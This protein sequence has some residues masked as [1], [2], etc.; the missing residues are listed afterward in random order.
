MIPKSSCVSLVA[1]VLAIVSSAVPAAAQS[2]SFVN[3]RDAVPLKFFSPDPAVTH[4]DLADPNT[5]VIGFESGRDSG[6]FLDD[7]F[8][9]STASFGN[10]IA[11]DTV[12]FM[13]V[14]PVGYYVASITYEQGGVGSILR[15]ADAVGGTNWVI[16]GEAASLGFFRADPTLTR[17]ATFTD[18]ELTV[19]PV[20]ITTS[21]AAFAASSTTGVANVE[22]TSAKVV[23][24]VAPIGTGEVKKN[25]VI[26]VT[27]FSGIYDALP[28][29][30]VGTATGV[31]GE[32][33]TPLLDFGASFTDVPGGTAHWTFIG[34][35]TYNAAAGTVPIVIDKATPIL[36]W[37]APAPVVA[38][39][40]LTS[41]QLNATANVAGTFV[42]SPPA[43]TVLTGTQ[44]L[45]VTFTPTDAV[46]YNGATATVTI[47][48][49][50]NTGV[51]IVNPGPQSDNVG[52]DV[53]LRVRLT[54]GTPRDRRGGLFTAT[55]L[56]PG[57]AIRADGDIRGELTTEGSYL[58]TVT[59]TL[60]GVAVSTAFQWTVLPRTR[61]G[62]KG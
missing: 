24:T 32:D 52:D 50:P 58:S 62:G 28:H 10:R 22:V 13:V 19:V 38:G 51:Q 18:S 1:L 54:G 15:V 56:P 16:N 46:N 49:Q 43:G 23:V 25:A 48:V 47:T 17:T 37:A 29:G 57:L 39:T 5:L 40:V 60:N 42:Y 33:L 11:M 53:R 30:A 20:S 59:H 8:R 9:A 55:G 12:S 26:N 35:A 45:S 44:A 4:V 31:D 2:V 3:I 6:N 27:G 36:S 7:E 61:K 14:A 34:D 41:T 21:L